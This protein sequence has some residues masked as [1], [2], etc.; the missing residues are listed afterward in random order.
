MYISQTSQPM[1]LCSTENSDQSLADKII[2]SANQE[3]KR[4]SG[5]EP[6]MYTLTK[7]VHQAE[8]EKNPTDCLFRTLIERGNDRFYFNDHAYDLIIQKIP[9]FLE[10]IDSYDYLRNFAMQYFADQPN[11]DSIMQIFEKSLKNKDFQEA[12]KDAIDAIR[13]NEHGAEGKLR[14]ALEVYTNALQLEEY[15]LHQMFMQ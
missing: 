2:L 13:A 5:Q 8:F 3:L 4:C 1:G 14:R 9:Q 15:D 6:I 11:Y 12:F 10:T 7:T